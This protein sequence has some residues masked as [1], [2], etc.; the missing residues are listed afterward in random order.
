VGFQGISMALN[1]RLPGKAQAQKT[2]IVKENDERFVLGLESI[3][4]S[5]QITGLFWTNYDA[6]AYDC[7]FAAS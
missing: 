5:I 3:H 1:R 7:I 2:N 6:P 4:L